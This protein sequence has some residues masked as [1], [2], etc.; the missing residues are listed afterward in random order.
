MTRVEK[1]IVLKIL[2]KQLSF[3]QCWTIFL[4]TGATGNSANK[5]LSRPETSC[6]NNQWSTRENDRARWHYKWCH[7]QSPRRRPATAG[8]KAFPHRVAVTI[9]ASNVDLIAFAFM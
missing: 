8:Q 3:L 9:A 5:T 6:R 4:A 1:N 7:R 2:C